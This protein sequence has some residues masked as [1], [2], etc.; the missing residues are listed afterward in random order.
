MPVAINGWLMSL[1]SADYDGDGDLDVLIS[2]RQ[3]GCCAG[4]KG[5][6]WYR[7]DASGVWTA[8][9]IYN[10][11]SPSNQGDPKFL[12]VVGANTV[13]VGGSSATQPNKLV[14]SVTA[15]SW[16]TWT[17]TEIAPYPSNV[18]LYQ[19]V[20]TCDL[21][22]DGTADYVL[23]HFSSTGTL[24]G[25]V[26]VN[27]ATLASTSIDLATGEKYDNVLCRDMDGDGDLDVLTTEQNAGLGIVWFRNPRLP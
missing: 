25:L 17:S 13:M 16:A 11:G 18:G 7:S 10:F 9:T 19:S 8:L 4:T 22:G 15:D 26:Y 5:S 6:K 21:T 14:K 24:D 23:S 3:A 2:E 20:A 12:E 27:G 1:L